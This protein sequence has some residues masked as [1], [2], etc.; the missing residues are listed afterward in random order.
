MAAAVREVS[1]R[2]RIR[3]TLV[4]TPKRSPGLGAIA[5][6]SL[7]AIGVFQTIVWMHAPDWLSTA[8]YIGMGWLA[9]VVVPRLLAVVPVG[10]FYWILA[11]G[12]IYTAGA[13]IRALKWPRATPDRR[14]R[15]F[16][17]HEIWHLCV[18][19]GSFAH[20]WAILAYASKVR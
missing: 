11:G 14:P 6:W 18:M 9:I 7:A 15:L 13:I 10:F 4:D 17:S 19:A 1:D 16:G 3:E 20:Y 5:V 12:T 2:R 8:L